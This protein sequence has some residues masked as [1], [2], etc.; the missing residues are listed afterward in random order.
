MTNVFCST[1]TERDCLIKDLV[2]DLF[3]KVAPKLWHKLWSNRF[4][5][6]YGLKLHYLPN[7]ID[8]IKKND[9]QDFILKLSKDAYLPWHIINFNQIFDSFESR[10]RMIDLSV[11]S[12]LTLKKNKKVCAFE[13][14]PYTYAALCTN[15]IHHQLDNV[16]PYMV[17]ISS[18]EI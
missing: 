6:R 5:S 13:P 11:P 17:G 4:A 2:A 14:N 7:S 3:K 12:F 10:N 8:I 9:G 16:I 18:E 1:K 15:I